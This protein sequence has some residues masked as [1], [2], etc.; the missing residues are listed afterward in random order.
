MKWEFKCLTT[1]CIC[2]TYTGLYNFVVNIVLSYGSRVIFLSGN[3]VFYFLSCD[4]T[5]KSLHQ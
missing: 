3:F 4:Y 5:R 2:Q 1:Y